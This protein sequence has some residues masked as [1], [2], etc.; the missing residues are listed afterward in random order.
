VTRVEIAPIT[1]SEAR[2]AVRMWH[3]HHKPHV[4]EKFAIG[5]FLLDRLVGVA[6]WSRP[7]APGLA[8]R[9]TWEMTRLA[10]GPDAPKY[11]ASRLIGAATRS[12][13]ESST[14]GR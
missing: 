11:T 2:D 4:G 3:S 8:D 14:R 10:V 7:V 9:R 1:R 12:S 13:S 5:A 6:V